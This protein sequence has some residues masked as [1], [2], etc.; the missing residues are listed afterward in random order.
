MAT[1]ADL[2]QTFGARL[3][4]LESVIAARGSRFVDAARLRHE[5]EAVD[6][7]A[8]FY[9]RTASGAAYGAFA[10]LLRIAALLV[11]WR[12][13]V[14]AGEADADRYLRAAKERH[15]IWQAEAAP[16]EGA[17]QVIEAANALADLSQISDLDAVLTSF[18]STPLPIGIYLSE[19]RRTSIPVSDENG[20]DDVE[21]K[22]P[23]AELA[24]AFLK[25]AI[26]GQPAAETHFLT[27][28]ESHDLELEVRVSRWPEGAETLELRPMTIEAAGAY[29]F[30]LFSFGHP[31]GEAPFVLHERG[32]ALIRAPQG[33]N[34]RPFEFRYAASF[35]PTAAEQPMATLGQRTLRI[36]S[37]DLKVHSL[38]G[39]PGL[40]LKI[41]EIREALRSP[42]NIPPDDLGAA[43]KLASG[44]AA[45]MG[46]VLQDNEIAEVLTE[47]QFQAL[48]RAE[49][50]RRPD[51]GSALSEHPRAAGG[52]TD[53]SLQGV[54]LELKVEG[55]KRLVL[56][57]CKAFVGQA[58]SYVH[59]NGK[60]VGVLCVLDCSPK[61]QAAAAAEACIGIQQDEA[62]G[63]S[64]PIITILLQAN[65]AKPSSLSR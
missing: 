48:V 42:F 56:E 21:E 10:E 65:L 12:E 41:I 50:R 45:Y 22:A 35:K 60:R 8:P 47:K 43:L 38:T 4:G 64:T 29:D 40:E 20:A 37:I 61:V 26:D 1:K 23:P 9:D 16:V 52:I 19:R 18:A 53:L 2:H 51:I 55:E 28:G 46:R 11:Q 31:G 44:L 7:V 15:R 6:G 24:V 14:L 30:P 13:A 36:E 27:P 33:L 62:S 49:L 5:A 34:A 39:Y 58:T 17:A 25:F 57:D 32:R 59:G 3:A 54:P 63:A